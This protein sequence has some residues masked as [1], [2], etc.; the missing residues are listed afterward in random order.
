MIRQHLV[1]TAAAIGLAF[2]SVAFSQATPGSAPKSGPAATE[3]SAECS[4]LTGAALDTCMKQAEQKRSPGRSE[5]TAP[6]EGGPAGSG[7]GG[8]SEPGAAGKG[9]AGSSR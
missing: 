5:A 3:R 9:A 6:R 8:T 2:S 4:G 7:I 1:F